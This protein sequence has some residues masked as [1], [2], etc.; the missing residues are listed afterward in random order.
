MLSLSTTITKTKKSL[1]LRDGFDE[2]DP[3]VG[4]F[5]FRKTVIEVIPIVLLYTKK[6]SLFLLVKLKTDTVGGKTVTCGLFFKPCVT[7]LQ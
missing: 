3:I 2:A 1:Y 4:P 6:G 5:D 7:F